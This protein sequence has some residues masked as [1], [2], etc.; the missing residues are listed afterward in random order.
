[1]MKKNESEIVVSYAEKYCLILPEKRIIQFQEA[2][3]AKFGRDP[4]W[5]KIISKDWSEKLVTIVEI[6]HKMVVLD[7]CNGQANDLHCIS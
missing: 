2:Y 6:G 3:I 4:N 1:M 5:S 7:Y